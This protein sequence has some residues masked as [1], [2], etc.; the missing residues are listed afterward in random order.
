MESTEKFPPVSH[1][2]LITR[3]FNCTC[4]NCGRAPLFMTFFH[5]HQNCPVCNFKLLR[6][7]GFFLAATAILQGLVIF[8][9]ML[10]MMLLWVMGILP[11]NVA[12]ISGVGLSVLFPLVFFRHSRSLWLML[13]YMNLPHEL[14]ANEHLNEKPKY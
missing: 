11:G 7:P 6:E 8:F 1:S 10:P 13:Y 2:D 4:P 12:M 3:G 9:V 14:P 5:L